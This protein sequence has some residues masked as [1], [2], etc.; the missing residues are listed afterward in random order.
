MIFT[1]LGPH[2]PLCGLELRSLLPGRRDRRGHGRVGGA[3]LEQQRQQPDAPLE[4]NHTQ[5]LQGM[6]VL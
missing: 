4:G 3:R 6:Q 5:E 1:R 2:P